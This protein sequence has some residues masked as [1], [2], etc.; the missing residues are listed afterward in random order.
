MWMLV[1]VINSLYAEE[2]KVE[3]RKQPDVFKSRCTKLVEKANKDVPSHIVIPHPDTNPEVFL[4]LLVMQWKER[5]KQVAKIKEQEKPIDMDEF[6]HDDNLYPGD[7][8]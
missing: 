3:W 7:E 6:M 5:E 1:L 8:E 2:N 4:Q